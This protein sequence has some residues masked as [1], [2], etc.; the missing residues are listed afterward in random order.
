MQN[1]RRLLDLAL[2]LWMHH[3][4]FLNLG[5]AAY[6]DFFGFC[7]RAFPGIPDQSIARMVAGIEV[8]CSARTTS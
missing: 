4:E 6:L 1:Y 8:D 5:Y 3:F 2:K 7:K